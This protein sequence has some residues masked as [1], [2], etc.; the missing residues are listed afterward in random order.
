MQVDEVRIG[1]GLAQGV[2][3]MPAHDH[4]RHAGC[5]A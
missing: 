5:A 3:P 1:F 2:L 4:A